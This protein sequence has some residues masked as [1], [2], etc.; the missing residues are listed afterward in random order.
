MIGR[1]P[2][3]VEYLEWNERW[4][5]PFGLPA[6][7]TVSLR[8]RLTEPR[9]EYGPFAYQIFSGTRTFEYPRAYYAAGTTPGMRVLEA[10]GG[11]SG[12]QFVFANQGCEG[13]NA[14]PYIDTDNRLATPVAA[15]ANTH[16]GH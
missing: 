2:L 7:Q 13:A 14:D 8:Q 9:R 15:R 1:L 12:L 3:P 16:T 4:G 6:A 5:A 10:G 11:V